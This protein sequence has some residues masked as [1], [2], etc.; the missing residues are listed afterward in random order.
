MTLGSTE[1]LATFAD[2]LRFEDLPE[3]IV[4]QAKFCLL[5]EVACSLAGAPTRV[6]QLLSMYVRTVGGTQE[7]TLLG[8]SERSTAENA[9]LVN[10]ATARCLELD[11]THAYSG[12]HVGAVVVPAA[13]AVAELRQPSG[14]ELLT[15]IVLGYEVALKVGMGMMP[16][17]SRRGFHP[18][19]VCGILGA[20]VAASKLLGLDREG[21]R[22]ALGTAATSAS[23]LFQFEVE[24]GESFMSSA[25]NAGR[26]ASLGIAAARLTALGY[27][28][29]RQVLEGERG[30]GKAFGEGIEPEALGRDLGAPFEL[31]RVD[32]TPHACCRHSRSAVEAT[33]ALRREAGVRPEEIQMIQVSTYRAATAESCL[34][35]ELATEFDAML[36]IPYA[37]AVACYKG[38][39]SPREYAETTLRDPGVN[40]LKQRVLVRGDDE[41][42]RRYPAST[43]ARVILRTRQGRELEHLVEYPK[44]SRGNPFTQEEWMSKFRELA[45]GVLPPARAEGAADFILHLEEH[46]SVEGLFPLLAGREHSRRKAPQ[47]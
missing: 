41:L 38:K 26:A 33:L 32:F 9:A 22:H 11:D 10:G 14:R 18:T 5:D 8:F 37:V 17:L 2:T 27:R 13:L 16:S 31:E 28:A 21:Y 6:G 44:G 36:S 47:A 12:M 3:G 20:A 42:D 40:A 19:G 35:Q 45:T 23:G 15:A 25:L 4:Q 29:S 39:I 7:A 1:K 46:S 30:F 24:G 34:R 43:P